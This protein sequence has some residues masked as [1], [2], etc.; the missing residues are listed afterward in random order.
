MLSPDEVRPDDE[1]SSRVTGSL[2]IDSQGAAAE[3][4]FDMESQKSSVAVAAAQPK[5]LNPRAIIINPAQKKNPIIRHIRNVP[6]EFS[7]IPADYV[8]GLTTCALFLSLKYHNLHPEYIHERLKQLGNNYELRVLLVVVDI[9][10]VHKSIQELNKIAVLTNCTL[11]LAWSFEEAARYLETYKS[12]EAKPPD[13]L[14]ERV[15]KDYHS[16]LVDALTTV[17][18]VN[19]TDVVTLSETF[20]R[21]TDIVNASVDELAVCPG[22]GQKKAQRLHALF[23]EPFVSRETRRSQATSLQ[24]ADQSELRGRRS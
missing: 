9:D 20:G 14:M 19:K 22:V 21:L 7:N 12:F 24:A 13:M 3:K 23:H 11:M 10:D 16:R 6:Y 18:A 4:L 1:S 5:P 15:E 8:M 2:Q 17:K